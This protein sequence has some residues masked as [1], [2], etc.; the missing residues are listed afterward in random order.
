[1]G[2]ITNS[3]SLFPR[4][5]NS[6]PWSSNAEEGRVRFGSDPVFGVSRYGNEIQLV[7]VGQRCSATSDRL[8]VRIIRMIHANCPGLWAWN[9]AVNWNLCRQ[10]R[11][12][13]FIHRSQFQ[14]SLIVERASLLSSRNANRQVLYRR[15]NY[16]LEL[17]VLRGN[18]SLFLHDNIIGNNI[19]KNWNYDWKIMKFARIFAILK[20]SLR[21]PALGS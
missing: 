12:I 10:L 21:F 4:S 5:D 1:M 20:S 15:W 11:W 7:E 18:S 2:I 8:R 9:C 14:E 6:R 16:Y 3:R 13:P 17:I 19:L